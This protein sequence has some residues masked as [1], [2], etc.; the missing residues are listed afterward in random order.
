MFKQIWKRNLQ[1]KWILPNNEL[2][3]LSFCELPFAAQYDSN[4][5][6]KCMEMR[7]SCD[8]DEEQKKK[9]NTNSA[10]T[11]NDRMRKQK[12]NNTET[13]LDQPKKN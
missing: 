2:C 11:E 3:Y 1:N 5:R 10:H 12:Q 6:G 7:H 8:N 13:L 4:N 9:N